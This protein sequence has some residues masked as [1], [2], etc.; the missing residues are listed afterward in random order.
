LAGDGQDR[1]EFEQWLYGEGDSTRLDVGEVTEAAT[2]CAD[3]IAAGLSAVKVLIR[4]A[5]HPQGAELLEAVLLDHTTQLEPA[6]ADIAPSR[7][8]KLLTARDDEDPCIGAAHLI[9]IAFANPSAI[10]ARDPASPFFEAARRDRA[11][12][13]YFVHSAAARTEAGLALDIDSNEGRRQAP[14]SFGVLAKSIILDGTGPPASYLAGTRAGSSTWSWSSPLPI[15]ERPPPRLT[16]GVD[17]GSIAEEASH[18]FETPLDAAVELAKLGARDAARAL[19]C[20]ELSTRRFVDWTRNAWESPLWP[21]VSVRPR[22]RLALKLLPLE[23]L[24]NTDVLRIGQALGAVLHED[25]RPVNDAAALACL[26]VRRGAFDEVATVG[27]LWADLMRLAAY[28]KQGRWQVQDQIRG[29]VDRITSAMATA[30]GAWA[31]SA[32]DILARAQII[33][34][35]ARDLVML[36]AVEHAEVQARIRQLAESGPNGEARDQAR[37]IWARIDGLALP[38]ESMSRWLAD[39]ASRAFDGLPLF[40]RALTPLARTWVGLTALEETLDRCLLGAEVR[41]AEAAR[42]QG[43]SQEEILT[44]RLLTELEVAFR[45]ASARMEVIAERTA[46]AITIDHRETVKTEEV[47]WGC[48]IALLLEAQVHGVVD[49]TLATLVQVKK[50]E[51]PGTVAPTDRWRLDVPQLRTLLTRTDSCCYWLLTLDGAVI[52][53]PAAWLWG[54]VEGR[55]AT[56]QRSF[57]VHYTD[58]R[59]AAIPLRQYLA[60]QVLGTWVGSGNS[61]VLAFAR[62]RDAR[63]APRHIVEIRVVREDG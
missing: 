13:R 7:P 45:D 57:T 19:A 46:G 51:A 58:V 4:L 26:G 49:L 18:W 25:D 33:G 60:E 11:L 43:A 23:D 12:I 27:L 38:G 34:D 32:G 52:A 37:G 54:M 3:V 35:H 55:G 30:G 31:L 28:E 20:S 6:L 63:N 5:L 47:K 21:N 50:P 48:D 40:P 36:A 10:E 44:G 1:T 56:M 39:H 17:H 24:P 62:G 15:D 29:V 61:D 53:T 9:L 41:F 16:R 59:H 22:Q 8:A 2:L 14:A 42:R